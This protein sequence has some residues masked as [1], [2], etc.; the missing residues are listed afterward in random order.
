M[1]QYIYISIFVKKQ[2]K[3]MFFTKINKYDKHIFY[4]MLLLSLKKHKSLLKL[5]IH[6]KKKKLKLHVR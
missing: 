2:K 5:F 4:F 3:D 6:L 1:N